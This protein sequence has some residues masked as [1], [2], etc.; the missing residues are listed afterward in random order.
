MHTIARKPAALLL[1]ASIA[2]ANAVAAEQLIRIYDYHAQPPFL[3]DAS[4]GSGLDRDIIDYL[5]TRLKG[6]YRF[7]FDFLPRRRLDQKL[8]DNEPIAVMLVN[9][10]WFGDPKQTRYQ[11][12]KPLL[13]EKDLIVSR[14]QLAIRYQGPASLHGLHFG[15]EF[16]HH[17]VGIDEAVAQGKLLRDDAPTAEANLRKLEVGHIDVIVVPQSTATYYLDRLH[18]RDKVFVSPTPY[19]TFYL[20]FLFQPQLAAA[21]EELDRLIDTLPSDARWQEIVRRYFPGD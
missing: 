8:H 5:N 18:L 16:G 17:Y 21:R 2:L 11:W 6:R 7:E 19:Q 10:A 12:S 15:G 9:P 14:P 1:A 4:K 13:Q 3:I 20:H